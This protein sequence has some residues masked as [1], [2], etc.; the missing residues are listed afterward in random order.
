M[1]VCE[2]T[3][4]TAEGVVTVEVFAKSGFS[5]F[6]AKSPAIP[7]KLEDSNV[8]VLLDKVT[9]YVKDKYRNS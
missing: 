4:N 6:Y 9:A 1:R 3:F 8:K 2:V 7:C 5:G